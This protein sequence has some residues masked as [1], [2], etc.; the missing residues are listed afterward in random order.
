MI[1]FVKLTVEEAL[2]KTLRDDPFAA[3]KIMNCLP[4]DTLTLEHRQS[5][6]VPVAYAKQLLKDYVARQPI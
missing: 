6:T 4:G 3:S 5:Y 2:E 1:S